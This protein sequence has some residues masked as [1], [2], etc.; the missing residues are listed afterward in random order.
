[1]SCFFA[2]PAPRSEEN[3]LSFT[4]FSNFALTRSYCSRLTIGSWAFSVMTHSSLSV[5]CRFSFSYSLDR[6]LPWTRFPIYSSL[7]RMLA[8]VPICQ[9]CTSSPSSWYRCPVFRYCRE[10]KDSASAVPAI[11]PGRTY[12]HPPSGTYPSRPLP[13]VHQSGNVS[14]DPCHRPH[15]HTAHCCR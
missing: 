1:M 8:M 4:F 10:W 12:H 9:I 5:K 15:N 6:R 7:R 14:T 2:T 13:P 3:V 11:S